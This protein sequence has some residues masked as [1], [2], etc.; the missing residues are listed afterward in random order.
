MNRDQD[1][2]AQASRLHGEWAPT[3]PGDPAL[4]E[5]TPVRRARATG[6]WLAAAPMVAL[7][8]LTI[9][10]ALIIGTAGRAA[11]ALSQAK[12]MPVAGA[13]QMRRQALAV[14]A[15]QA[16]DYPMAYGRFAAL[17]D[18]GDAPSALMAL[19]MVRHGT[20]V[21]GSDWS[22]T[23]GQVERWSEIA[24]RDVRDYGTLIAQHD[25]GE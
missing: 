13:E 9:A 3:Q 1:V 11:A 4:V 15:F 20:V 5:P 2:T 19:A 8:V 23:P 16:R 18:A 22:I 7:L 12:P 14:Q 24:L 10:T 17:A 6:A 21:F 25:R